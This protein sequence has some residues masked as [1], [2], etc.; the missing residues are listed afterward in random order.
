MTRETPDHT[1]ARSVPAPDTRA[2]PADPRGRPPGRILVICPPTILRDAFVM[3]LAR[4]F[5]SATLET[6]DDASSLGRAR[7]VDLVLADEESCS[8]DVLTRLKDQTSAPIAV[9]VS[10]GTDLDLFGP[11]ADAFVLKTESAVG[12]ASAIEFILA[13]NRYVSP[14]LV[15]GGRVEARWQAQ[16]IERSPAAMQVIQGDRQVYVNLAFIS[17]VE[18]LGWASST[19]TIAGGRFW[20]LVDERQ[21]KDIRDYV[22]SWFEGASPAPRVKV[23]LR[24]NRRAGAWVAASICK[25]LFG[26]KPAI[27]V[28]SIDITP[29]VLAAA[30]FACV[31][32]RCHFGA[33]STEQCRECLYGFPEPGRIAA[34][35][36]PVLVATEATPSRWRVDA[37]GPPEVGADD[38]APSYGLERLSAQQ[39]AV[40]RL[41]ATGKLNKQ[42]AV[43]LGIKETTVKGYI[44]RILRTLD[45][46][47]RTSAAL[48]YR[49]WIH[50]GGE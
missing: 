25:I 3:F 17:R 6:A 21:Q 16:L 31:L 11:S 42:I 27:G 9:L 33:T 28:V 15:M 43:E 46:P 37:Q 48:L 40:L 22:A 1:G 45:L 8:I 47:N 32:P 20:D 2:H 35:T 12:F 24:G 29:A 26:G 7:G 10:A 14:A 19:D 30:A 23:R 18:A 49:R 13:G 39:F 5:P 41:V 34:P 50:Q 44:H 38:R 4:M 36:E